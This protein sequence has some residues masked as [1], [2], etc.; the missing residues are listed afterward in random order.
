MKFNKFVKVALLGVTASIT[1]LSTSISSI[2][3]KYTETIALAQSFQVFTTESVIN[4]ELLDYKCSGNICSS[5]EEWAEAQKEYLQGSSSWQFFPGEKAGKF[6]Y[7]DLYGKK[8][9]GWWRKISSNSIEFEATKTSSVE[10]YS[11]TTIMKGEKRDSQIFLERKRRSTLLT[12][13][14]LGTNVST[15]ESLSKAKIIV[16]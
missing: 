7:Q 13:I 8:Y 3:F 9:E 4:Y 5:I 6:V 2:F 10:G 14:G 16:R 1:T 11:A 12:G 15:V